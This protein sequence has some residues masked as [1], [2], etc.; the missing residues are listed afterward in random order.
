MFEKMEELLIEYGLKLLVFLVVLF[1]GWN[2]AKYSV[3]LLEKNLKK[4]KI[5]VS[6]HGFL[7]TM[8][9]FLLKF[10]VLITSARILGVPITTF[11]A[12]L[13]AAG[14]AVG[15]ALKDSLSNFAAGILLLA[16]RPF[17]VG[18]FIESSSVSGTVLSIQIL[19]TALNTADNKRVMVPNNHLAT[20]HI[21]NYSIEPY[22]RVDKIYSV[23]Y[24]TDV[25]KVK[26]ILMNIAIANEKILEDRGVM[27]GVCKHNEYSVDFDLKVW[28]KRE[29]YFEVSY[30]LNETV[31]QVF[32]EQSIKIPYPLREIRMQSEEKK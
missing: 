3:R 1:A 9:S 32:E 29:D 14:L 25:K 4:S 2:L 21:I 5:D 20:S 16:T 12:M 13:S 18:D 8:A 6:I 11:I 27:L 26:E 10:V 24:G 15:L 23:A 19:Y 7:L 17:S 28:V 22:R 31:I 30:G